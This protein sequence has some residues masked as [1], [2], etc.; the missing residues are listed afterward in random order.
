MSAIDSI[1][2]NVGTV[3]PSDV[4]EGR[5]RFQRA[6]RPFEC[7]SSVVDPPDPQRITMT[8]VALTVNLP[9]AKGQ[10]GPP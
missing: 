5:G 6:A 10:P 1:W 7:P 2:Y 8:V 9:G 3:D 4:L